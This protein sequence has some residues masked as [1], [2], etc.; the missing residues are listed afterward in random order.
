VRAVK[1]VTDTYAGIDRQKNFDHLP[2]NYIFG[3]GNQKNSC[4]SA[5]PDQL[6]VGLLDS[7]EALLAPLNNIQVLSA[8]I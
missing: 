3:E 2:P 4:P 5:R 7:S 8:C 1:K 6:A